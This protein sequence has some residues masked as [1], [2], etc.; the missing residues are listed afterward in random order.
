MSLYSFPL[1]F[2]CTFLCANKIRDSFPIFLR[3]VFEQVLNHSSRVSS[4]GIVAGAPALPRSVCATASSGVPWDPWLSAGPVAVPE[5]G[6]SEALV[7]EPEA[8]SSEAL[9]IE[10]EVGSLQGLVVESEVGS[11]EALDL[12][13]GQLF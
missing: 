3:D 6:S 1:G 13:S 12:A 7:L 8:G 5:V 10:P 9:V 2:G 11:S 4:V